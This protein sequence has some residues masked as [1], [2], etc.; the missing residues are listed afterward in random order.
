ML[1]AFATT[2]VN[3]DLNIDHRIIKQMIPRKVAV[4][5]SSDLPLIDLRTH[6]KITKRK[7]NPCPCPTRWAPAS[8]KT[9]AIKPLEMTFLSMVVTSMVVSGSRK[10]W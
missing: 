8:Q 10:R 7:L 4:L 1:F 6:G 9:G 2:Q 5:A 3:I